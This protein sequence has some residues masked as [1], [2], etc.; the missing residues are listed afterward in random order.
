MFND[1]QKLNFACIKAVPLGTWERENR[2]LLRRLE[3]Y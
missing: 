3:L 1:E 2:Q